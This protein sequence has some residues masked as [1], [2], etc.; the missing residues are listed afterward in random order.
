MNE[1]AFL[2]FVDIEEVSDNENWNKVF[3]IIE[4]FRLKSGI[5]DVFRTS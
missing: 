2:A 3:D 4:I 1:D 5:E